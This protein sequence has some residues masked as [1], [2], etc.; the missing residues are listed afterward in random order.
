[1]SSFDFSAVSGFKY[2]GAQAVSANT[3]ADSLAIDTLGF[4]GVA[5]VS[6]VGAS[7]LDGEDL[8]ISRVFLEGDDTNVANATVIDTAFVT[9]NPILGGSNVAVKAGV[10]SNKRYVFVRYVPTTN[11]TANIVTVGA[12]GYPLKAPTE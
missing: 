8:T 6:A 5:I 3:N 2:A 1:M 9:E 11:A 7:T 10:S 4:S 12:L